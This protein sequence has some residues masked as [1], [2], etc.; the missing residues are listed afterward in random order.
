MHIFF[1]K[2]KQSQEENTVHFSG[3][4]KELYTP[5]TALN[6]KLKI[7]PPLRTSFGRKFDLASPLP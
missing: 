6:L 4:L 7:G 3:H 2:T 5:G 1:L